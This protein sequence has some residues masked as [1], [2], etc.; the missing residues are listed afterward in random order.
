MNQLVR[1]ASPTERADRHQWSRAV[2]D[3]NAEHAVPHEHLFL[4]DAR[5]AFR[6]EDYRKAVI[7]AATAAEVALSKVIRQR[8]TGA[9]R[10]AKAIEQIFKKTS[11]VVELDE[12]YSVLDDPP[13]ISR[14]RLMNQV[15]EKRNEAA[16][17]GISPTPD[18]ARQSIATVSE[19]LDAVTPV[20]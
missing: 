9:G 18:L 15:A 16:H 8:L 7:D 12:L 10:D 13:P 1:F 3:T 6:R 4:R 20:S 5:A 2:A 19:L 17:A 11:G 14:E